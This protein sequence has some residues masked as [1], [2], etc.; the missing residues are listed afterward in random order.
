M[1][2]GGKRYFKKEDEFGSFKLKPPPCNP[3]TQTY[4]QSTHSQYAFLILAFIFNSMGSGGVK[5]RSLASGAYQID[6]KTNVNN[7]RALE[8]FFGWYYAACV[9]VVL[10]TFIGTVYIQDHAGW[11]VGFGLPAILMC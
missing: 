1:R 8:S 5:P 6:N 10:I 11:K 4:K 7:G 3:F 9:T 2:A